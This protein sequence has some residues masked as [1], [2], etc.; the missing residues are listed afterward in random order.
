MEAPRPTVEQVV[1]A[2]GCESPETSKVLSLVLI[3]GSTKRTDSLF[4]CEQENH[5]LT[6][7]NLHPTSSG[8]TRDSLSSLS[9]SLS[10][11]LLL[12]FTLRSMV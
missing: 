12:Y 11:F 7:T 6:P 9:R 3:G 8:E 2:G 10:L 5:Y 4:V 1:V